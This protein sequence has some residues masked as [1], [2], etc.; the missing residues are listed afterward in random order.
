M[1][2]KILF[3]V[4]L[5]FPLLMFIL[6]PAIAGA[7]EVTEP[8]TE[9]IINEVSRFTGLSS[10]L[11]QLVLESEPELL[12]KL[13]Q[14]VFGVQVFNQLLDAK[15]TEA[16]KSIFDLGVSNLADYLVKQAVHPAVGTFFG[17]VKAYKASLEIV[18]DYIVIPHFDQE[19][20]DR[21]KKA[22]G[23]VIDY[24]Y[25]NTTEAFEEA[26]FAPFGGYYLLKEEKYKELVKA[27]GYNPEL[28]GDKLEASLRRDIDNFW[29][30]RLEAKYIQERLKES[31][32]AM[33]NS[34]WKIAQ[35]EID[36]LQKL[37]LEVGTIHSGLFITPEDLPK[38]WWIAKDEHSQEKP[39]KVK[40]SDSWMQKFDIS[41]AEGYKWD[42]KEGTYFRMV[43]QRK[44]FDL[45]PGAT[46]YVWIQPRFKG[47]F[48]FGKVM[49]QSAID[50]Q[51]KP[52]G[53]LG[54]A[55]IGKTEYF[56]EMNFYRGMYACTIRINE[57]HVDDPYMP[58]Y[59]DLIYHFS[60]AIAKKMPDIVINN[61][62]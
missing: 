30:K 56:I 16:M 3:S 47:E 41:N 54:A 52:I 1:Q 50:R 11:T 58:K 37:A 32:E 59:N 9:E 4:L 24:K 60:R 45:L 43:G 20:Y 5:F 35:N 15:D 40:E 28:V 10:D 36:I 23:G 31:R 61:P 22:R 38:G 26:T 18:R 55:C 29:M 17:A 39:S 48:D 53:K 7:N 62:K 8:T 34:I 6:F 21:Y 14:V 19:T 27:K 33:V 12:G 46:M 49:V 57:F 51:Q 44:S 42:D 2:K 25:A 13:G